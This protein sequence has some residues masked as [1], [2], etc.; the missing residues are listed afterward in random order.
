[1]LSGNISLPS[2]EDAFVYIPDGAFAIPQSA[3][4]DGTYSCYSGY[5]SSGS[6]CTNSPS[7][8]SVSDDGS[9]IYGGFTDSPP[10]SSS[11]DHYLP[12]P[13]SLLVTPP[14]SSSPSPSSTTIPLTKRRRSSTTAPPAKGR[15]PRDPPRPFRCAHPGCD[16]YFISKYTLKVHSQSH[17]PKPKV[18]LACAFDGCSENFSRQHD[19]LRHEVLQHGR[20]CEFVC[21]EC[22]RFFSTRQTLQNHK[23]PVAAGCTRWAMSQ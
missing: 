6:S 7:I 16:R 20:V 15:N 3:Q 4:K 1:M 12:N 14:P 5:S 2:K 11:L 8:F 19:R 22:H 17:C 10:P 13:P 18:R 9:S 23:C 21:D